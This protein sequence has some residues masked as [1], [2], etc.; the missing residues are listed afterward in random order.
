MEKKIHKYNKQFLELINLKEDNLKL[1]AKT[2]RKIKAIKKKNK[3]IFIGNGGSA[4]ICS[5]VTVD[6]LKNS[7]IKALNF[8]DADLITCF[9]NDFGHEY[10]MREALKKYYN[11]GDCVVIISSSGESKNIINAADWCKNNNVNLISFSGFK[12]NNKLNLINKKGIGFWI[13]SKTYNH[14]ETAHLFLIL[15]IIDHI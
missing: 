8:N 4:A 2:I 9:A 5:H 3:L 7:K 13:D 15:T 1:I 12:K 6:F 11:K 14:V 10:W